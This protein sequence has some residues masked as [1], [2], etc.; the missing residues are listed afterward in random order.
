MIIIICNVFIFMC[1]WTFV[2]SN[3]ELKSTYTYSYEFKYQHKI[4]SWNSLYF[5]SCTSTLK[6]LVAYIILFNSLL[7][8]R[9]QIIGILKAYFVPLF[10]NME[11]TSL[12]TRWTKGYLPHILENWKKK[13]K[14]RIVQPKFQS[15]TWSHFI[16]KQWG[17]L[18]TN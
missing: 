5:F 4:Q 6:L 7:S 17:N 13:K 16:K 11:L 1:P 8:L 14:F 10:L 12:P 15:I 3:I 9:Y 2:L 18:N